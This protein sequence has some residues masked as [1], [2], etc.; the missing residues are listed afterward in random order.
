M[1]AICDENLVPMAP[2]CDDFRSMF[3]KQGET[4][5]TPVTAD[6]LADS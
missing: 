4:D 2:N 3:A 5:P 6:D 1:L